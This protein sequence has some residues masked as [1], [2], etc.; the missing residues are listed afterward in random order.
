[1][2]YYTDTLLVAYGTDMDLDVL[3]AEVFTS[4]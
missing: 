1:M 2:R 3:S 4:S